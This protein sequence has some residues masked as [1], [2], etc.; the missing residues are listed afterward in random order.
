LLTTPVQSQF[1]HIFRSETTKL[2]DSEGVWH[3]SRY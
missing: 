2:Y 3:S 1:K